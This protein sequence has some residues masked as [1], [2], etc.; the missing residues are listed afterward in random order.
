[1]EQKQ[2]TPR[3]SRLEE[4]EQSSR[5]ERMSEVNHFTAQ[6]YEAL[7]IVQPSDEGSAHLKVFRDLRTQ[8]M[9]QSHR[10]NFSCLVTSIVPGGG[11]YVAANLAAT[12]ALDK[13]RTSLYLDANL[14]R[15]FGDRLLPV[16]SYM[17][18]TDFLD[19][20]SIRVEEIV[21]ASSI[22]RLRVIPVGQNTEGGTEKLHSD[23]MRYLFAELKSR[24]T[25]RYMIIDAPS[26]TEYEA[27]VRILADLSDY[28]ILVVPYGKV[29]EVQ[30]ISAIDKIGKDR[31]AGVVY[32]QC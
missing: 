31:L 12:I 25:D 9:K 4:A 26:P 19:D 6:E 10:K 16:Q 23:R 13:S 17:G 11:T 28:V 30:L 29:T 21:Y 1:M 8:L 20:K 2:N 32:N 24:Y 18:L 22:P 7:K 14:Y 5:I 27:E 3:V 15:P